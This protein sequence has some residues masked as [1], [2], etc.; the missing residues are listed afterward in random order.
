MKKKQGNSKR[1]YVTPKGSSHHD[2]PIVYVDVEDGIFRSSIGGD[3]VPIEGMGKIR[4]C[5]K[6]QEK[7]IPS[8]FQS[9]S[10]R[11][12]IPIEKAKDLS[13]MVAKK[14]GLRIPAPIIRGTLGGIYPPLGIVKNGEVIEIIKS[15]K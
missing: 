2:L 1:G 12:F 3:E 13:E 7:L 11:E 8:T 9:R 6:P 10:P 5:V 4:L 15:L 14:T